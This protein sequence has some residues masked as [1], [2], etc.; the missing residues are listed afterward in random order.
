MKNILMNK[1]IIPI[2][3]AIS[4][5]IGIG[6]FI[7]HHTHTVTEI[8]ESPGGGSGLSTLHETIEET[9]NALTIDPKMPT[10]LP[11]NFEFVRG[12]VAP[13]GTSASFTYSDG[14]SKLV[15]L[16]QETYY[17]PIEGLKTLDQVPPVTITTEIDGKVVST[18][19]HSQ[20]G[21]TDR[22]DM[23]TKNGMDIVFVKSNEKYE[24]KLTWY[25]DG[26]HYTIEG[27]FSKAELVKIWESTQ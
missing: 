11:A 18:S 17:D 2:I 26:I 13:L 1:K 12:H 24:P 7:I 4:A 3:L 15:Y 20:I 14:N 23:F 10:F 21:D 22:L 16:V 8:N 25:Q 6:I 27:E 9:H 19:Q 5:T